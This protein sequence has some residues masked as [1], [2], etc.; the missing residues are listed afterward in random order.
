[1]DKC[2]PLITDTRPPGIIVD[3][4]VLYAPLTSPDPADLNA[5]TGDPMSFILP[6]LVDTG[7]DVR[8]SAA[9]TATVG[10][11]STTLY[12]PPPQSPPPPV[13]NPSPPPF[14]PPPPSPSPPPRVVVEVVRV[15]RPRQGL[16]LVPMSAQLELFG[17]PCNPT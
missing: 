15:V 11:T 8:V 13:R 6:G 1:V 4:S 7:F 16:T 14:S 10:L 12:P 9:P 3:F 17:P 5:I 2:K